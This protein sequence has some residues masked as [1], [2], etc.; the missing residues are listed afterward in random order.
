MKKFKIFILLAF[1]SCSMIAQDFSFD[2]IF[3]D[4][5]GNRDTLVLGFDTNAG[6]S[7]DSAFGEKNIKSEKWDSIF[8][9]RIGNE[10]LETKTQ[11][12]DN[13]CEEERFWCSSDLYVLCKNWPLIIY[14]NSELLRNGCSEYSVLTDCHPGGWF[15]TEHTFIATLAEQD[16]VI[17]KNDLVYYHTVNEDTIRNFFIDIGNEGK[18]GAMYG[19]WDSGHIGIN[20]ESQIVETYPSPTSDILNIRT[21]GSIIK[22]L[23]L[24]DLKGKLILTKSKTESNSE[25]DLSELTSGI[26]ILC[27]ESNLGI[28]Q[29]KIIKE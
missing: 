13:F 25:L 22:N 10:E 7:I 26:Y 9:V 5:I 16:T 12:K 23:K 24:Y 29:Q 3:V 19:P 20:S 6:D 14:W 15:D 8:E 4:G 18:Y 17:I 21:K 2:L 28:T 11:I 27:I 1:A